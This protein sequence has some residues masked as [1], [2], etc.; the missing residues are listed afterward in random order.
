MSKHW[1]LVFVMVF[2]VLSVYLQGAPLMVS[3]PLAFGQAILAFVILYTI[4]LFVQVTFKIDLR[5]V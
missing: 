4:L 1:P 5:L 2:M 3:V